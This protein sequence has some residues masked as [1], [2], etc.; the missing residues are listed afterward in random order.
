VQPIEAAIWLSSDLDTIVSQRAER[1]ELAAEG[2]K[3]EIGTLP[4][5]GPTDV[6]VVPERFEAMAPDA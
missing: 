1:V 2:P 5:R 4:G 6:P 3:V